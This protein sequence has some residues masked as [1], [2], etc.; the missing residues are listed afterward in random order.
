MQICMKKIVNDPM[1]C[2]DIEKQNKVC[3]MRLI[4][5]NNISILFVKN[6]V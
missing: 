2:S 6:S 5:Y 3:R 4:A 1:P